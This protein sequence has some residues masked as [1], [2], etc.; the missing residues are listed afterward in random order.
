MFNVYR[1]DLFLRTD[2]IKLFELC[3]LNTANVTC[4]DDVN[5]DRLQQDNLLKLTLVD[6]NVPTESQRDLVPSVV[7]IVDH[8]QDDTSDVYDKTVERTIS[9]VGSCATLI[10]VDFLSHKREA[11]EQNEDLVKL[12][13]GVILLDTDNL[14]PTT[15]LATYQDCDVVSQLAGLTDIDCSGLFTEL[16]AA[17]FDTTGLSAYDLL[18]RDYKYAS[19][20]ASGFTAGGSSVPGSAIRFLDCEDAQT[21]LQQF[22]KEKSVNLLLVDAIFYYSDQN[23][24]RRQIIIY[25]PNRKLQIKVVKYLL[26]EGALGLKEV[27]Q[28]DSSIQVFDQDNTS[29]SRKHMLG[30]ICA[31]LDQEDIPSFKSYIDHIASMQKITQIVEVC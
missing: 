30:L 15:G 9:L 26:K 3:S 20:T 2:A 17:K 31:A 21:A 12:L 23:K 14:N 19:S 16:I 24:R 13:L 4:A 6:H 10:A 8:H 11:L 1:N 28:A 29:V 18:R 22:S 5:L 7:E 27:S 25:C